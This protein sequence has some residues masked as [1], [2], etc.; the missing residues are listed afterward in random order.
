[1][2]Q[3]RQHLLVAWAYFWVVDF[4]KCVLFPQ[5][6]AALIDHR[7]PLSE[8]AANFSR[9]KLTTPV[10]TQKQADRCASVEGLSPE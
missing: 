9:L 7:L 3:E 5:K 2:N 6:N 4:G 1:M 10:F 8:K